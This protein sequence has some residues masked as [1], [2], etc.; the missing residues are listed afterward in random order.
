M[1]VSSVFALVIA[2]GPSQ[3][4]TMCAI[5]KYAN[6]NQSPMKRR[7]A[8]NFIRSAN[9]PMINAGVI[10]ANVN[11]N[12]TKIYSGITTPLLNVAAT[13][14]GVMPLKNALLKPPK[15]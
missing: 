6:V 11:W 12:A 1:T 5:G 15:T 4:H 9:A 2:S 13:E 8:E 7:M 3:Y 10:A 14:S